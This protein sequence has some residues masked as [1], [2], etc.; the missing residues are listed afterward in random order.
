L[1]GEKNQRRI[2]SPASQKTGWVAKKGN[3]RALAK[4]NELE[5]GRTKK[6]TSK[7]IPNVHDK[8]KKK[9]KISGEKSIGESATDRG[10]TESNKK[11][12][13]K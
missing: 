13:N 5:R 11:D 12:V 8:S 1:D 10:A 9:Q 3:T 4:R 7:M 6:T 2:G